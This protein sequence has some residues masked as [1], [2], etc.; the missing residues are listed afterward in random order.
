MPVLIFCIFDYF[1]ACSIWYIDFRLTKPS[2]L[3][4]LF[5]K[6]DILLQLKWYIPNVGWHTVL[7]YINMLVVIQ[8]PIYPQN[9]ENESSNERQP[10]LPP[11]GINPI[12]Y[13]SKLQGL[14]ENSITYDYISID[15]YRHPNSHKYDIHTSPLFW[16]GINTAN[17]SMY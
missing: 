16:L 11:V 2:W 1:G 8:T 10:A 5:C 3:S 6:S 13:S 7:K 17:F 14:M 4:Q 12:Y 9:A 15:S